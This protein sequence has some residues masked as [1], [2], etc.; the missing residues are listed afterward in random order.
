MLPSFVSGF[1]RSC[2]YTVRDQAIRL[3]GSTS[4]L[5]FISVEAVFPHPSLRRDCGS[6]PLRSSAGGSP[7]AMA[8]CRP[9]P[10]TFAG[11]CCRRRQRLRLGASPPQRRF[12]RSRVAAALE[13]SCEITTRIPHQASPFPPEH[14]QV[15]RRGDSDSALP[16][17]RVLMEFKPSPFSFLPF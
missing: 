6:D 4:L 2:F 8:G 9:H 1:L 5:S 14:H 15:W 17:Y 13:G 12:M 10:G 11:L 3:P 16:V 7:R